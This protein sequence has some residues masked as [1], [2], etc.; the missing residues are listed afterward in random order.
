[1]EERTLNYVFRSIMKGIK[2]DGNTILD[3]CGININTLA[4]MTG[5]KQNTM[6]EK[7]KRGNKMVFQTVVELLD[8]LGYE[9]IIQKK[10]SERL[11]ESFYLDNDGNWQYCHSKK[12]TT[13]E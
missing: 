5:I 7:L 6:S 11:D 10:K 2:E 13:N 12:D 1:M 4:E 3:S 8:K 9:I